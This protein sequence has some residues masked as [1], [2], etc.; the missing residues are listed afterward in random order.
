MLLET[1]N[2]QEAMLS[3]CPESG[4]INRVN[5]TNERNTLERILLISVF[6]Q[7]I[8]EYLFDF[9]VKFLSHSLSA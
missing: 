2:W 9:L 1:G 5:W 4:N 8:Y 6:M 7:A 3:F